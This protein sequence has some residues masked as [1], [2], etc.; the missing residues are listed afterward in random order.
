MDSKTRC[1]EIAQRL[2]ATSAAHATFERD[3]LAGVYDAEWAEWYAHH[4]LTNGWNTLFAQPWSDATLAAALRDA[5]TDQRA[6]A[7]HEPWIEYYT[8][9]FCAN[10]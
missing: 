6:H 10:P 7:P 9:R 5:D 1:L 8:R 4:L 3:A 2:S